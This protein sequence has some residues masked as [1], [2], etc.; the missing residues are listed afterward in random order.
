MVASEMKQTSRPR[1][2]K[3]SIGLGSWN[4]E[5]EYKDVTLTIG[6]AQVTVDNYTY[7]KGK[8]NVNNG[9]ISQR[10]QTTEC[11]AIC[12]EAFNA[13]SYDLTL[14][15]RKQAGDEGFLIIF[16]YYDK[17]NFL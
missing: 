9:I 17:D 12:P 7:G 3:F 16:D 10:T 5:V 4:T 1:P 14:K 6:D 11:I 15:A 2:S 8:W 13:T